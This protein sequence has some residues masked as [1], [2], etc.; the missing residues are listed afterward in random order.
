M[1]HTKKNKL[2]TTHQ[3]GAM[4]DVDQA[5]GVLLAFAI[6]HDPGACNRGVL[7]KIMYACIILHNMIV[8]GERNTYK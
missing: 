6:I 5:F 7:A 3:E 1:Q 2:Y 8:A 4:K